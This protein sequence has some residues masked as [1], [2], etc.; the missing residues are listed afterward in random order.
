MESKFQFSQR[1]MQIEVFPIENLYK[2]NLIAL[3]SQS[4]DEIESIGDKL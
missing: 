2:N 3:I 1:S 4:V